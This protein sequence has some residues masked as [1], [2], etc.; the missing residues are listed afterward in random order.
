MNSIHLQVKEDDPP[1]YYLQIH[2]IIDYS[3]QSSSTCS[4]KDAAIALDAIYVEHAAGPEGDSES[5][6][7]AFWD[8]LHS[9]RAKSPTIAPN[10]MR[11]L[12]LSV[13]WCNFHRK[14]SGTISEA[15]ISNGEGFGLFWGGDYPDLDGDD[16]KKQRF[17]NLMAYVARVMA[18]S[19]ILMESN[20]IW[21]PEDAVEGIIIRV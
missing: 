21:A 7:Y 19:R 20:V 2:S 4:A 16:K 6:L 3:I 8:L 14:R 17:L 10:R 13:N 9:S 12:R 18:F 11:W 15:S 5:F 1:S